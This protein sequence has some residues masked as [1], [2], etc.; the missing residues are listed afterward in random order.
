MPWS[1]EHHPFTCAL[2]FDHR[3]YWDERYKTEGASFEW[4]R[5]WDSLRPVLAATLAK[6]TRILQVGVGTSTLQEDMVQEG[7][8]S[9]MNV[10]YS[11]VCI[12]IMQER[13][14]SRSALQPLTHVAFMWRHLQIMWH[15]HVKARQSTAGKAVS[16]A[17]DT[18]CHV[19]ATTRTGL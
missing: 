6:A 13:Q 8:E 15:F 12:A 19:Q 18:G 3:L 9:I 14:A 4:Y 5:T 7:Y 16:Q 11:H 10:D 1:K 17:S 2:Q